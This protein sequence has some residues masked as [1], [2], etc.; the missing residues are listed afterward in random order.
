ME[1]NNLPDE[2]EMPAAGTRESTDD[3]TELSETHDG[4]ENLWL[5]AG[6][7]TQAGSKSD[8]EIYDEFVNSP[9][10]KQFFTDDTQRIINK[11]FREKREE[12]EKYDK[13]DRAI[14]SLAGLSGVGDFDGIS[15]IIDADT[16]AEDILSAYPGASDDAVDI[17]KK[18]SLLGIPPKT[19]FEAYHPE[20]ARERY[21]SEAVRAV[22]ENI[23][24]RRLRPDEN[25]AAVSVSAVFTGG[26]VKLTREEREAIAQ[27]AAKGERVTI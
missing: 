18:A 6:A 15:E 4:G 22:T 3:L 11:R 21:S 9:R 23:R 1:N 19:L 13:I 16:V 26:T 20:L 8:R 27:R 2:N 12:R 24:S 14:S 5:D 17:T 7:D 25:G 10:F